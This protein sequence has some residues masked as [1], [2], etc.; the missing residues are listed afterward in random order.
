MTD[1]QRDRTT[2]RAASLPDVLLAAGL[3][4]SAA[5]PYRL[6]ARVVP[7]GWSDFRYVRYAAAA[8]AVALVVLVYRER[9]SAK[10]SGPPLR[11]RLFRGLLIVHAF[12]VVALLGKYVV[13]SIPSTWSHDVIHYYST[14]PSLVE[15]YD[16]RTALTPP[17]VTPI[18]PPGMFVVAA[19]LEPILGEGR[20]VLRWLVVGSIVLTSSM[21]ARVVARDHGWRWGIAGGGLFLAVFPQ[22]VWS[23]APTKPE[24]LAV[25]LSLVGLAVVAKPT[26][27]GLGGYGRIAAGGLAFGAALLVKFTVAGGV[28]GALLFL[29]LTRRWRRL[30]VLAAATGIVFGGSY[31]ALSHATDGGLVF[32]TLLGNMAEPDFQKLFRFGVMGFGQG[33]FVILCVTVAVAELSSRKRSGA[34]SPEALAALA[35]L[36]AIG[37]GIATTARPGSSANYLLEAVALG[38]VLIALS[39]PKGRA[40]PAMKG[41][42][43]VLALVMVFLAVHL[44]SQVAL[45]ARD[46]PRSR[47]PESIVAELRA[48]SAEFVLSDPRYVGELMEA[49]IDPLVV[50][51]YQFTMMVENG[52]VDPDAVTGPM[53]EGRVPFAVLA[54]PPGES[55]GASE[56]EPRQSRPVVA[57]LRERYRCGTNDE[58]EMVVCR[59]TGGPSD[60]SGAP[61]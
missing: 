4:I 14:I 54:N 39:V 53:L 48:D 31:L 40:K 21:V 2:S 13:G 41:N 47:L 56:L 43:E 45:L 61:D 17:V 60:V 58:A 19:A 29:A 22:V 35:T 5:V 59:W 9:T 18:Y 30:G 3:G 23:G 24:Y 6:L 52:V 46:M 15:L 27:E 38:V 33:F 12:L 26:G 34:S 28:A 32:F 50:D 1:S 57:I 10:G 51:S 42:V 49:G 44:P 11:V 55:G 20:H 37:L 25:A 36:V 7:P 16:T 8:A